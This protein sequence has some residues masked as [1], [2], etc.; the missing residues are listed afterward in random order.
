MLLSVIVPCFNEEAVLRSTHERLTNVLRGL[1]HLSFEIIYVDDGSLDQ[2]AIILAELQASN[3]EVKVLTLARNFGQQIAVSAG[4]EHASGDAVV[5]IDSDLQDP[6]EVIPEMVKLWLAG[7]DV[8]YG[9]RSSREGENHFKLWT[10]KAFYRLIN[11]LSETPIPIDSGDFRLMDR[12]VVDVLLSMPERDRFLRGMVGWVG[13]KQVALPYSRAS[14]SAG[15]SKYSFFKMLSFAMDGI[16][17]FSLLPLKLAVWTGVVAIWIALCGIL[18]A[19]FIRMF[20]LYHL[21][22]GRGW[23]SLFVA[24]LFMGGVQLVFLGIVGEYLGRIYTEVKRRPLYVVAKRQG[25]ENSEKGKS[26]SQDRAKI[27]GL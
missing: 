11:R 5:L 17:S 1:H 14:R 20:G 9:T 6:P 22:V 3:R 27:V 23:A 12:K 19:L 13:F 4:I 25:F 8:V 18:L 15:E 7:S 26:A 21:Q 10:A 16:L 2:T 24:V